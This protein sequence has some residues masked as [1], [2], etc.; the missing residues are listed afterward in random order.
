[1]CCKS[2]SNYTCLPVAFFSIMITV[3]GLVRVRVPCF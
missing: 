2:I 3:L 1:M